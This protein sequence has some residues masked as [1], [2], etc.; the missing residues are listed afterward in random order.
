[1]STESGKVS[2]EEEAEN[3]FP[4]AAFDRARIS[5]AADFCKAS[6]IL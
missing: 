2:L 3:C 1:M 4:L 5:L 6:E